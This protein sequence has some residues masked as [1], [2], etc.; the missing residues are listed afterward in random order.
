MTVDYSWECK[1]YLAS[2]WDRIYFR[3][4]RVLQK[5][6]G[7]DPLEIQIFDTFEMQRIEIVQHSDNWKHYDWKKSDVLDKN[8]LVGNTENTKNLLT[9]WSLAIFRHSQKKFHKSWIYLYSSWPFTP[10]SNPPLLFYEDILKNLAYHLRFQHTH[11]KLQN[12]KKD[13]SIT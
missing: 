12:S 1:V 11:L 5:I 7:K 2:H 8:S 10:S 6:D 13:L 3:S 4:N 9:C